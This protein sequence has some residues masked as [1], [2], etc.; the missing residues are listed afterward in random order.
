MLPV[1][2]AAGI[3][4]LAGCEAT[5]EPAASDEP[6]AD[7]TAA[8]DEDTATAPLDGSEAANEAPGEEVAILPPINDDPEQLVGL[9]HDGLSEKLGKP[10]LIRRDGDAEIWQ[11]RAENCVLD[12]FL[13]GEDK[14]VV[15]VDLRDRGDGD[16]NS[17]RECFV[18]MLRNALPST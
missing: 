13:Y 16:E 10:A 11:Y 9:D 5:Q 18:G 2:L 14:R 1:L 8:V 12:L 15:H 4:L 6:A 17:V 7:T 3:L